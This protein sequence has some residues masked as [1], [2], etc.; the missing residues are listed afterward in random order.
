[1]EHLRSGYLHDRR[2]RAGSPRSDMI[3]STGGVLQ[4]P[5]IRDF[6]RGAKCAGVATFTETPMPQGFLAL[7]PPRLW[8]LT[9]KKQRNM[10]LRVA[11]CR[12]LFP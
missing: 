10:R 8:R 12:H 9:G 4:F 7:R 3:R 1:M 2:M 11:K 5:A 6:I